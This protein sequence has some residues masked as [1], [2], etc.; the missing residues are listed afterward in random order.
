MHFVTSVASIHFLVKRR[1]ILLFVKH[2]YKAYFQVP[3]RDQDK[4]WAPHIVCHNCEEMLRDWM[5]GK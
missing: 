1:N 4:K 2:A 5:K 3:L